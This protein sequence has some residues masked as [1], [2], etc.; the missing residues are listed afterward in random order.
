MM[1][2]L[3][4]KFEDTKEVFMDYFLVVD[5]SFD[6]SLL[7]LW[8]DFQWFVEANKSWIGGSSTTTVQKGV[9]L[10]HKVSRNGKR[11]TR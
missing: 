3:S 10:G 8:M 6:N 11:L 7:N 9:V 2:I 5:D 1:Y 4:H